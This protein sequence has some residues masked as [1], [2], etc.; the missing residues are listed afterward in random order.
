MSLSFVDP[1]GRRSISRTPSHLQCS[2]Q[3]F[4]LV[5]GNFLWF[6][7]S[8]SIYLILITTLWEEKLGYP[9]LHFAGGE[10]YGFW[11][12][13]KPGESRSSKSQP[14]APSTGPVYL[15]RRLFFLFTPGGSATTYLLLKALPDRSQPSHNPQS[16]P[17]A[18]EPLPQRLTRFV[19]MVLTYSSDLPS[20][21]TSPS[22]VSPSG[23]H[24]LPPCLPC[25]R[26]HA[27]HP[28]NTQ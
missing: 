24:F 22:K 15:L 21:P 1:S 7:R 19:T 3:S 4:C 16:H 13:L 20:P 27:W 12:S 25:A 17:C 28:T 10:P 9:S 11:C 18:L 2:V 14:C 5:V 6:I 26:H 8:F 23:N